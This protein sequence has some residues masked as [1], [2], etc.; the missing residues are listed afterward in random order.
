[1]DTNQPALNEGIEG[2]PQNRSVSLN[3]P[4]M[5][6]EQKIASL[7]LSKPQGGALR[8]LSLSNVMQADYIAIRTLVPRISNPPIRP[9][10]FDAL[11]PSD[12]MKIAGELLLFFIPKTDRDNIPK[13]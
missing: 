3:V 5:R 1:M 11:D 13:E 4:I 12:V 10:E 6:G 7:N 2:Y 8:G 9:D